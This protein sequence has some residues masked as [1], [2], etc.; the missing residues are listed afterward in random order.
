VRRALI[1]LAIAVA[2]VTVLFPEVVFMGGSLSPVGLNSVVNGAASKHVVDL[3]PNPHGRKPAANVRDIGARVWQLVPATKFMHDAISTGESPFWNPYSATG[4][5]GP[6]T[7]ADMKL[8]PFVLA[9]ALLGASATAFT[10]V[11]LAFVVL[12]LYCLQQF[13]TRTLALGRVAATGA[14]LVWLLTGFGASDI[15]SATGAPYVLF[16]VLLY[17]L[18]EYRRRGGARRFLV[19]VGAYGGFILTTFVSTQLLMLVL[20]YAVLLVLDAPQWPPEQS[21]PARAM[22]ILRR[23]ALVPAVALGLTAYVWLPDLAVV[24]RG[25]SDFSNYGARSLSQPGLREVSRVVTLFP[26]RGGPWLGYVG[27]VPVLVVAGAWSRARGRQR[28]LLGVTVALGLFALVLHT[29]LPLVR[30]IGDLPGLR[31][32]RQ[33]YWAALAGAAEAIAVGIAAA[34]VGARGASRSAVYSVGALL[35]LWFVGMKGGAALLGHAG[36][37][38]IGVL[39]ATALVVVVVVMV[40]AVER[41]PSRRHIFAIGAVCLIG[42]EL[43]AYQNHAR[44]ARTDLE[45][46]PPR[47]V[48]FLRRNLR[49]ERIFNAGRGGIYPEW[50]TVLGIP[51]IG[52]LNIAQQPDYRTF[53]QRYVLGAKGLFLE[54]GSNVKKPFRAQA[55]ALDLLAVRYIVSDGSMPRFDA[56]LR[57]RYPLVFHD[58]DAGVWVYKNPA[59][60]PRAFLS[61]ALAPGTEVR[62]LAPFSR[63]ITVSTDRTMLAAARKVG[64][65]TSAAA[66]VGTATIV[67]SH[68]VEVRIDVDATRPSVLVL[69]DAD[70]PGWNATVDGKAQPVARVDQIMR[71]VI[72]PAG[73]ST[74]VFRY[75]SRPRDI[76]ALV[77]LVTF[78]LIVTGVVVRLVRSRAARRSPGATVTGAGC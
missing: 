50:G 52:T 57:S 71:G 44:V 63:K 56:G 73:R 4:S 6:E 9:V 18:A 27:I 28:R 10:F 26:V 69:A 13:F 39:A 58:G 51:Q 77:S 53:F 5:Y 23:H 21:R 19:A 31:A 24:L 29:G 22:T 45:T 78:V 14:C 17:T 11:V 54:V 12:G 62:P 74:V 37:S 35:A 67:G 38:S 72:V 60:F 48:T 64:I 41:A 33:D 76:G 2:I 49:G 20:V 42:L 3:Y 36:V 75:R 70:A 8:S 55:T 15:N 65:P 59:A 30:L 68:N 40:R 34:V 61:P 43:F 66:P 25:G 47:Y 16:P 46:H 32:V 1:S 7:L